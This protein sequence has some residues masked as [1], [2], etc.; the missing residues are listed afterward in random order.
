MITAV[1][2][3]TGTIYIGDSNVSATRYAVKLAAG[4]GVS[5]DSPNVAGG[6]DFLDMSEIYFDGGTTGDDIAVGYI[7]K[8][9]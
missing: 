5:I 1:A 4:D 2:G 8:A 7:K 9:N 6:S 3:N